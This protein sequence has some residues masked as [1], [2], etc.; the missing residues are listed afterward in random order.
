MPSLYE[1]GKPKEQHVIVI[2]W[3]S[4]TQR[5]FVSK[6][7]CLS[8][9]QLSHS[10]GVPAPGRGVLGVPTLQALK[11]KQRLGASDGIT[12]ASPLLSHHPLSACERGNTQPNAFR[13]CHSP[14]L[15]W[16]F[17]YFLVWL[18]CALV[19]FHFRKGCYKETSNL[20]MKSNKKEVSK[21]QTL[22]LI[23]KRKLGRPLYFT[24][25][26][27]SKNRSFRSLKL[28]V[29]Q[30]PQ[31]HPSGYTSHQIYFWKAA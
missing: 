6:L 26:S 25:P 15:L 8:I 22:F 7:S 28:Y 10:Y 4:K 20:S 24:L 12:S 11:E 17:F 18:Y 16:P 2:T 31:M 23:K 13:P 5:R 9:P 27:F 19:Y 30:Q 3:S 21:T 29:K 14:A 1:G